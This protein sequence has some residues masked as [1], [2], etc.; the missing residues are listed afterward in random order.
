MSVTTNQ[1]LQVDMR[2]EQDLIDDLDDVAQAESL[3]RA[4]L[5]RRLLRDGLR[6]ERMELGLKRYRMGEVSLGRAAEVARVSLYELIDRV[7]EEA[8]PYELDERELGRIDAL[9]AASRTRAMGCCPT[10]SSRS[11]SSSV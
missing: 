5:A 11:R 9:P 8:I 4:E 1:R 6:R 10:S 3:D 2:L 7:H